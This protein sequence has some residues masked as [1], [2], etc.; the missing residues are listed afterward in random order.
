MVPNFIQPFEKDLKEYEREFVRIIATPSAQ[1]PLKDGLSTTQSKF[2]GEPFFPEN[3]E[4][5]VDRKGKPMIMLAQ[6]NFS[7]IPP[8]RDFPTKGLLQL[9]ISSNNWYDEDATVIYHHSDDLMGSRLT[10]F[11]FLS[12]EDYEE[13][14]VYRPHR[15]SFALEID[16]GGSE[17]CQFDF[18]FGGLGFWE[19]SEH[20]SEEEQAAMNSY[21]DASGHK[22]GGYAEFTQTD[23][24]DYDSEKRDDIQLLQ[25]DTDEQILFGDAGL[26]HVFISKKALQE[27]NFSRAYF[28]W[29]CC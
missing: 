13:S 29:D 15:L 11:S 1:H 19:F 18:D 9:F 21:F 28:Y 4:Y 22:I 16:N 2:L 26:G 20:L 27:K 5:P 6:L 8:L 12:E 23:P 17:D 3:K 24:R 10:N 14:P 25:I 7:E